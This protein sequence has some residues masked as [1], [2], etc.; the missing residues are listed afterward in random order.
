MLLSACGTQSEL[1][2]SPAPVTVTVTATVT[3]EASQA[4]EAPPASEDSGTSTITGS[5]TLFELLS[6][7]LDPTAKC[8]AD[9]LK[10]TV[11]NGAGDIVGVATLDDVKPSKVEDKPSYISFDCNHTYTVQIPNENSAAYTFRAYLDGLEDEYED[12][13]QLVGTQELASGEG[14]GLYLQFAPNVF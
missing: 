13:K 8:F 9:S 1:A 5:V 4:P 12:D 6:K 10:V 2:A 7:K 3:A 11:A 14:P